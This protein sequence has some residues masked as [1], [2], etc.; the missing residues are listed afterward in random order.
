M[1]HWGVRQGAIVQFSI[2]HGCRVNM[3]HDYW[4]NTSNT[5]RCLASPYAPSAGMVSWKDNRS[6]SSSVN[7]TNPT[8]S[9]PSTRI[10]S[11]NGLRSPTPVLYAAHAANSKSQCEYLFV[12][13]FLTNDNVQWTN[14]R[15][16][17]RSSDGQH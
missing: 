5:I 3:S 8:S 11:N 6:P 13:F 16:S 9:I 4:R 15:A 7:R 10:A 1:N 12:K 2:S 17:T 14:T